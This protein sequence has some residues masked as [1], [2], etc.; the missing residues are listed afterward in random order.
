[1]EVNF[2]DVGWKHIDSP[3]QVE[4]TLFKASI[5]LKQIL[6]FPLRNPT[7]TIESLINN[8]EILG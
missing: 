8:N 5:T 7:A 2:H 4:T 6:Q 1:M 3:K